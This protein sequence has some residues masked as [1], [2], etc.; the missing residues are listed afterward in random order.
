[1]IGIDSVPAENDIQPVVAVDADTAVG[2]EETEE[3]QRQLAA[4]K[5]TLEAQDRKID[6]DRSKREEALEKIREANKT[7]LV[8]VNKAPTRKVVIGTQQHMNAARIPVVSER[9]RTVWPGMAQFH[10]R[11]AKM[12][13]K[14][15]PSFAYQALGE[16]RHHLGN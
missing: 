12:V 13:S 11:R 9:N 5:E 2:V 15:M 3:W 6:E 14:V 10:E 1:M 7:A 8:P 4:M 16:R